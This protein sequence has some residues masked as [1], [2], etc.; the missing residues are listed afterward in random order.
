MGKRPKPTGLLRF[1]GKRPDG[2]TVVCGRCVVWDFTCPD[3][4]ASSYRRVAATDPGVVAALAEN[5]KKT[6][7]ST[8]DSTLYTFMPITIETMGAF[9]SKSLKFI[10][11]LG[12]RITLHTGDPL[13][14][15]HLIQHL[16]VTV[17]QKNA[18]S[19]L[20]TSLP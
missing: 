5:R 9:G 13:A 7:Y 15:C 11:E 10:K 2:V 19:I 20:F 17:Q 8:L 16:F 14:S 4:L 3:T 1:D 6:K 12:K 18:A